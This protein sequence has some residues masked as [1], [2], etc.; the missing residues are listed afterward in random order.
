[1]KPGDEGGSLPLM[2]LLFLRRMRQ[3]ASKSAAIATSANGTPIPIPSFSRLDRPES[4]RAGASGSADAVE[5]G[6]RVLVDALEAEELVARVVE[7]V[8]DDADGELDPKLEVSLERL[9]DDTVPEENVLKLSDPD[10]V[11]DSAALVDTD[12]EA[13]ESVLEACD[14]LV[15]DGCCVA[16]AVTSLGRASVTGGAAVAGPNSEIK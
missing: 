1:M 15:S 9:L 3:H 12:S 13:D 4:A 7:D 6:D 16:D 5:Y 8:T 2:D 14:A 11:E 10:S